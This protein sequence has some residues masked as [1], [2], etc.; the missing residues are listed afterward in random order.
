MV[1]DVSISHHVV[2]LL[3]S[4]RTLS[5]PPEPFTSSFMERS[6]ENRDSSTL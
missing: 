6:K 2:E 5:T 1:V 3:A 4:I